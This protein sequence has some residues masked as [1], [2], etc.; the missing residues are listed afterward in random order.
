MSKILSR[1]KELDRLRGFAVLMTVFIHY[2]RIF[3][4][5]DM[6]QQ[7]VHGTT[8]LNLLKNSWTG[9]DLFFVIS[10]YIISKMIV[11]EIEQ[12]KLNHHD[13]ANFIKG[14]FIK[15]F[16]RIY[17]IAW[18]MFFVVLL[19]CLFFNKSGGFSTP[20]NTIEAG[21]AIFTYTFNYY[22]G[23]GFYHAFT[24]SPYWSLSLEEQFY[25]I[26]P[27]FLIFTKTNKQRVIILL[28]LLLLI[29]FVIRPLS[30]DNI[31]FTQNRCDGLIYGCLIYYLSMQPWF[32]SVIA[33]HNLS[34]FYRVIITCVLV[35]TLGSITAIGFS[36]AIVIPLACI[37]ASILVALAAM[38]KGF[39]SF[40][41]KLEAIIDYCGSRSYSIYIIHFPMFTL[42]QE[43]GYRLSLAYH[44]PLDNHLA[45]AYTLTTFSLTLVF[46]EL[47][48]RFV[49]KPFIEKGQRIVKNI[50][51]QQLGDKN[52]IYTVN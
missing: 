28:G 51:N 2:T 16:F 34:R 10:G 42:T 14:F 25:L 3:F 32:K 45:L 39:I 33:L 5:W 12:L 37:I 29:T 20:E 22:F 21:I 19:C 36:N 50:I 49:E 47:S 26:M 48:Y 18:I 11:E 35:F 40:F 13:L 44:F 17:P 8:V 23:L 30:V 6:H 4:P 46:S 1:N 31:F 7:Y 43:I 38:E 52:A 41:P 27:F 15:R 9:V 24:L